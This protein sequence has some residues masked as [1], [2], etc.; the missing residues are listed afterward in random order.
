[1]AT[2]MLLWIS[3]LELAAQGASEASADSLPQGPCRRC[4]LITSAGLAVG[5]T[6]TFIALDQAWY[7]GY[8]RV[9]F[10]FFNDG[11]EWQLMDKAGHF[12]N[13]Y[14]ISRFGKGLV[15]RCRTSEKASTWAGAGMAMLFL[16]GVEV[17]DGTSAA[18]GFSVW[19]MV[20]NTAGTG[21][22]V[23]QELLWNEQRVQVKLSA[24]FTEYAALRPE[25]LGSGPA[26]RILKDYNGHTLWLSGNLASLGR[27][28][29]LPP[30]LNMAVGYGADGMITA[31]RPS[32]PDDFG[33]EFTWR[34]RWF[35]SP[36]IDLTR[37]RTR[38]KVLRT[39]FF[40]LNSVKV[41]LPA[42]EYNSQGQWRAHWLYF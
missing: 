38:S 39:A 32:S 24:R 18:W 29:Q 35:L 1:M 26:E 13:S 30:W 7:A 36:D 15:G 20:A 16:T 10:Q 37:I 17:L 23:G 33:G 40:V 3:G 19:D 4:L 14:T 28:D 8:E 21:V 2:M 34:R 27:N 12:F 31:T 22:F 41:P 25:L 5:T 9:P 6:A 42:L 11:D